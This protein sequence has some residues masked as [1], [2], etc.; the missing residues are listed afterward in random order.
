MTTS[1]PL[2]KQNS[3]DDLVGDLQD[4][5]EVGHFNRVRQLC[6]DKAKEAN[7]RL[8]ANKKLKLLMVGVWKGRKQAFMELGGLT[9]A[10]LK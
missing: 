10:D 4:S 3:I 6:I 8:I 2:S 1:K 7:R 5:E 9:E